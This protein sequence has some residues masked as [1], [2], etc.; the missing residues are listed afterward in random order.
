MLAALVLLAATLDLK[1]GVAASS[2]L[3]Y[4]PGALG[5][6]AA[7]AG[8]SIR[9]AVE[10]DLTSEL[11]LESIGGH[12]WRAAAQARAF[13]PVYVGVG[14]SYGGYIAKFEHQEPWVK[15]GGGPLAEIGYRGD[16]VSGFVRYRFPGTDPNS[17]SAWIAECSAVVSDP[18]SAWVRGEY[19]LYEQ[20]GRH[21][22]GRAISAGV[23]YRWRSR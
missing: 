7:E 9:L 17:A 1:A 3:G 20:G 8:G 5:S 11:K 12:T 19:V 22:S 15:R 2:G 6:V 21:E 10:A 23:S 18:W 14:Y 13:D 4:R 16:W